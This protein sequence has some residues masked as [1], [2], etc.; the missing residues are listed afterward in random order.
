MVDILEHWDTIYSRLLVD[1]QEQVGIQENW[2]TIYIPQ[3][4]VLLE[5]VLDKDM[6]DNYEKVVE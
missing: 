3:M 6:V 4:V 1:L 5:K 2:D